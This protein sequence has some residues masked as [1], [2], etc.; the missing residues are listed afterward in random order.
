MFRAKCTALSP[1]ASVATEEVNCR[2]DN[3]NDV[4]SETVWLAPV[5]PRIAVAEAPLGTLPTHLLA[6]N[7]SPLTGFAQFPV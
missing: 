7:Q 4:S 3:S 1:N 2:L 6:S 5:A